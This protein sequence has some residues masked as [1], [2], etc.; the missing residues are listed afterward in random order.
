MILKK[1]MWF[2][3]IALSVS[4][5][6]LL[7][8][9]D[10]EKVEAFKKEVE[11]IKLKISNA[12]SLEEC[13]SL[14]DSIIILHDKYVSEKELLDKSIYPGD[15][16]STIGK[17]EEALKLRSSDFSVITDLTEEVSSMKGQIEDLTRQN[18]SLIDRINEL[19]EKSQKDAAEISDLKQLVAQLKKN[20]KKRDLLV[21]GMIDTLLTE[22]VRSPT[23]LDEA[24]RQNIIGEIEN[25]SLFYNIERVIADNVSYIEVT[26]MKVPDLSEMLDEYTA[27]SK[28]WKQL[29]EKMGDVYLDR[30]ERTKELA[31]INGL[32]ANWHAVLNDKIWGGIKQEFLEKGIKL[33]PFGD[34]EEF[35]SSVLTFVNTEKENIPLREIDEL[36]K[37]HDKFMYGVYLKSVQP[38]WIPFLIN[39]NMMDEAQRDTIQAELVSWKEALYPGP[40]LTWLYIII[41]L[42]VIIQGIVYFSRRKGESKFSWKKNK[43]EE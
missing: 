9:S 2:L 27:F 22:F 26:E 17:L 24:E 36:K 35:T 40:D 11:H 21:R 34:G 19:S 1:V 16:E 32:F 41:G 25:K 23:T 31:Y 30:K 7:A 29:G 15:F 5:T 3:F 6:S 20:I 38:E 12:D 43:E 10:Y 8:Q 4:S 28:S 39:Q 18:T 33:L 37:T 42:I 13:K 14:S